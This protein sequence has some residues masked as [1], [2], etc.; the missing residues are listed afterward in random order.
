MVFYAKSQ[1]AV[2]LDQASAIVEN[3][4]PLISKLG[5]FVDADPGLVREAIHAATLD[6]LQFHGQETARDCE[7][8]AWPYIKA[9]RIAPG[10]DV[11][12]LS[13]PFASAK[14]LLLDTWVEGLAGGT[15]QVF[16][17]SLIPETMG[18]PIVLAGGLTA[19]NVA[20]AIHAVR[21]FAVDVSG[22]IE[23]RPGLKDKEKM[24]DFI[25]SVND[26]DRSNPA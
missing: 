23:S 2:S 25:R 8:Y 11:R 21:P 16:D 24:Q 22:G 9:L 5:L 18:K 26:V 13:G 20:A 6:M 15:G 1:R 19:A 10:V 4:P 7:L 14:G 12:Q 3:L 17:W